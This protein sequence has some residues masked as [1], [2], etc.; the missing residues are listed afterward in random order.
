M[1]FLSLFLGGVFF[2][3]ISFQGMSVASDNAEEVGVEAVD[4]NCDEQGPEE[5]LFLWE[6]IVSS[7]FSSSNNFCSFVPSVEVYDIPNSDGW[8]GNDNENVCSSN[9]TSVAMVIRVEESNKE[10]GSN[11]C[12][13]KEKHSNK[14]KPPVDV[15]IKNKVEDLNETR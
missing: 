1:V 8:V 9:F 7:L 5:V 3:L 2:A 11:N 15:I 10:A 6:S 13:D 14:D 4:D 12:W